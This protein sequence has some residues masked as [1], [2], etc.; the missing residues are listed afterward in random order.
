MKTEL[1]VEVYYLIEEDKIEV[2]E[3]GGESL[4]L[5]GTGIFENEEICTDPE[6]HKHFKN[7]N[8]IWLGYF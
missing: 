4:L 7:N 6:L 8:A 3:L 5:L 1:I 2:H